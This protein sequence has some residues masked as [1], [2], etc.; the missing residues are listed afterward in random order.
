MTTSRPS[1]SVKANFLLP[2]TEVLVVVTGKQA[3]VPE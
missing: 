2:S 1:S 3:K